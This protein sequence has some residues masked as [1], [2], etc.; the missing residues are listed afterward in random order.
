MAVN[1]SSIYSIQ[2]YLDIDDQ[3]SDLCRLIFHKEGQSGK[4]DHVLLSSA[5][6]ILFHYPGLLAATVENLGV[7]FSQVLCTFVKVS[8]PGDEP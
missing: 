4:D 2:V 8:E 6:H 3:Y 1:F 5:L 7:L